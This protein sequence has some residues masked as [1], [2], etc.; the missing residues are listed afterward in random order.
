MLLKDEKSIILPG[1]EKEL[2][3]ECSANILWRN[4]VSARL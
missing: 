2:W 1:E 3:Q 4:L